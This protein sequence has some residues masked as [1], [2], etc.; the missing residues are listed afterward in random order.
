M[1]GVIEGAQRELTTDL[2]TNVSYRS[3]ASVYVNSMAAFRKLELS[4]DGTS[5]ELNA[6]LTDRLKD[7]APL[8]GVGCTREVTVE[9]AEKDEDKTLAVSVACQGRSAVTADLA[10]E[11]VRA[12][13]SCHAAARHTVGARILQLIGETRQIE[14]ARADV[15]RR[16]AELDRFERDRL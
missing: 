7:A 2:M 3:A 10:N 8:C 6:G 11:Y 13:D 9:Y 5:D 1:Y 4:D 12:C 16:T 14:A 15:R